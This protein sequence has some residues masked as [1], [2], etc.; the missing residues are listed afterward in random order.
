MN[1]ATSGMRFFAGLSNNPITGGS[2]GMVSSDAPASAHSFGLFYSPAVDSAN[3]RIVSSDGTSRT[4]GTTG[5]ALNTGKTYD[6]Y[7]YSAPGASTLYWRLD[8]LTDGV[9]NE[10]SVTA[11]LPAAAT[12]MRAGIAEAPLT[13]TAHPVRFQKL[14]IETDR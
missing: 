14:Y 8:N 6:I 4:N 11:T 13:T 12:G 5:V 7:L 2:P 10:G 1:N 3:F 9:S